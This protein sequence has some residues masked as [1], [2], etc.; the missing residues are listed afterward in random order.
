MCY[1]LCY[2]FYAEVSRTYASHLL[3]RFSVFAYSADP[4]SL[5][6]KETKKCWT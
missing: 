6:L 5:G 1:P 4:R 2:L 3:F